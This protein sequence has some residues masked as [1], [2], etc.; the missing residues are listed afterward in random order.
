MVEVFLFCSLKFEGMDNSS[1]LV[2]V[3][4]DKLNWLFY[5]FFMK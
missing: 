1:I 3:K 4:V 5:S 2:K